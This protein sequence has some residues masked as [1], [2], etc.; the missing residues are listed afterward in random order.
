MMSEITYHSATK[1]NF[2]SPEIVSKRNQV[3]HTY[4]TLPFEVRRHALSVT[5]GD[6]L[7]SLLSN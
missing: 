2:N 1:Q 7:I 4:C 3:I 6:D 5:L